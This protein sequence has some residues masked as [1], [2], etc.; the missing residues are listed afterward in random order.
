MRNVEHEACLKGVHRGATNPGFETEDCPPSP[1][2][3]PYGWHFVFQGTDTRFVSI[4]CTFANEG[5]VT[6][7]IDPRS[8][9]AYVFTRSPDTLVDA[10]AIAIGPDNEF[11]LSHVCSCA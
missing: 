4:K 11:V 1:D 10:S 9:H 3:Y 8:K 6:K 7:I 2:G 5:V